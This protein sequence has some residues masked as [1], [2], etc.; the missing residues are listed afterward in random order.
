MTINLRLTKYWKK[1]LKKKQ[2][3]YSIKRKKEADRFFFIKNVIFFIVHVW[4]TE[5]GNLNFSFLV[6]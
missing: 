5:H 6:W 4:T 2:K 1:K 3:K